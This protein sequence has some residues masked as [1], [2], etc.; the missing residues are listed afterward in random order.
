MILYC[1]KQMHQEINGHY[2]KIIKTNPDYQVTVRSV[3]M[4]LGIDDNS[5]RKRI[6]ERPISKLVLILEAN[7]IDSPTKGT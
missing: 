5:N 6:L 7:D 4:L 2:V 1:L 3:T